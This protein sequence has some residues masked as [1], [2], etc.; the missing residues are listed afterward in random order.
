MPNLDDEIPPLEERF[1]PEP[2]PG[3]RIQFFRYNAGTEQTEIAQPNPAPEGRVV[4][5]DPEG[6]VQQVQWG[7]ITPPTTAPVDHYQTYMV[8]RNALYTTEA[9]RA[10]GANLW[11]DGPGPFTPTTTPQTANAGVEEDPAMQLANDFLVGCDPE[12]ALIDKDDALINVAQDN[13]LSR[14]SEIGYDHGGGLIELRP[15]PAKSAFTLV[16]RLKALLESP[17]LERY[18]PAKWKAGGVVKFR[19]EKYAHDPQEAEVGRHHEGMGMGGHIHLDVQP[20]T[21]KRMYNGQIVHVPLSR[22]G[23]AD[24]R[25]RALDHVVHRLEALDIL[26]TRECHMRRTSHGY[27]GFSDV[28]WSQEAGKPP[29]ME[30]RT[31]ASWLFDPRVAMVCLTAAKLAALDPAGT[32]NTLGRYHN[33]KPLKTWFENFASKD[34]DAR[35]VAEVILAPGV[36]GAQADPDSDFKSR[37]AALPGEQNP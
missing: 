14:R 23:V 27:G 13:R 25:V 19:G 7:P 18:K 24:P 12:F 26:P 36:R 10:M 22:L 2:A 35:R 6:Q 33:F 20:L 29:R 37:W 16:R 4:P 8:G 11:A 9:L 17:V 21:Q 31:M 32:L 30:Y 1:I 5:W 3:N 34:A 28:R 15:G